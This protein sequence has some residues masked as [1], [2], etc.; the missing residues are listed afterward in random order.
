M[1]NQLAIRPLFESDYTYIIGCSALILCWKIDNSRTTYNGAWMLLLFR[2]EIGLYGFAWIQKRICGFV[3]CQMKLNASLNP[4][5]DFN[6]RPVQEKKK[7]TQIPVGYDL[8]SH[9][10]SSKKKISS[11]EHT[12]GKHNWPSR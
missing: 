12:M 3:T 1:Y 5:S 7:F 6:C 4:I 11:L 8:D 10:F 2:V 9:K